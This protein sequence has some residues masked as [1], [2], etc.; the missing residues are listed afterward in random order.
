M[1]K[2]SEFIKNIYKTGDVAKLL[3]IS[4]KTIQGYDK[5][6]TLNF[7][8]STSGRR[9]IFKKDLL[10]FLDSQGLLI[11]DNKGEAALYVRET[12]VSIDAQIHA[13][14][15]NKEVVGAYQIYKESENN[16]ELLKLFE[17]LVR[18]NIKTLYLYNTQII[19]IVV[20][21]FIEKICS[22][23]NINIYYLGK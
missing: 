9:F 12:D 20:Y 7:R 1:Y 22:E 10:D 23:N 13:L 5:N 21:P 6:G 14:I 15:D 2:E 4:P 3:N 8:R 16:L 17:Q 18:G 11:R 19:D